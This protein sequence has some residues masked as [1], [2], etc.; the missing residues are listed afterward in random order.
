[1]LHEAS[2]LIALLR[3]VVRPY[4]VACPVRLHRPKG[5]R[6][7]PITIDAHRSCGRVVF[8]QSALALG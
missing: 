5:Q 3:F 2:E 8:D 6:Q 4:R 1:M 7:L